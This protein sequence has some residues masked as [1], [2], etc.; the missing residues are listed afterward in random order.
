MCQHPH[1]H[2]LPSGY[3]RDLDNRLVK[4]NGQAQEIRYC[5]LCGHN[6][7]PDGS[8]SRAHT[9]TNAPMQGSK[10]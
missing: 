2:T 4:I 9:H 3:V 7:S 8:S 1:E 6:Y 10:A 5:G